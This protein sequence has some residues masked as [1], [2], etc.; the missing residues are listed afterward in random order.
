VIRGPGQG[1]V[2]RVATHVAIAAV[3]FA[4]VGVE[5]FHPL[6]HSHGLTFAA[7]PFSAP[8]PSKQPPHTHPPVAAQQDSCPV[9]NFL[10]AF[11]CDSRSLPSPDVASAT[12]AAP[13][14]LHD[15][16]FAQQPAG[17]RLGA[18]SPPV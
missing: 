8:S 12:V 15:T 11:H 5:V 16:P 17:V 2:S 7:Q 9:C 13:P 10:A 3:L 14:A 18:R 6:F 4:T 1:W